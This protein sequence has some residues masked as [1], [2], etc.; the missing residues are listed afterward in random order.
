MNTL[1]A[2][3]PRAGARGHAVVIEDVSADSTMLEGLLRAH[4][5]APSIH[6]RPDVEPALLAG[7][8]PRVIIL[9]ADVKNGFN[10]CLRFRKDPQLR[11]VPLILMTAKASPEVIRKHKLLATRADAYLTKPLTEMAVMDTLAELLPA[12]FGP[13]ARDFEEAIAEIPD[14]TLVSNGTLES[15]VVNYVEEEVRTLKTVVERLMNEKSNLG[16]KVVDLESQMRSQRQILDSG[17][18]RLAPR[19]DAENTDSSQAEP[20]D[21]ED[22]I[23]TTRQEGY[24]AGLQA[25]LETGRQDRRVKGVEQGRREGRAEAQIEFEGQREEL[26][27]NIATL[28]GRIKELETRSK[29]LET[30]AKELAGRE[31]GYRAELDQTTELFERLEGGYKDALAKTEAERSN[32]D[33]S[34]AK[35]EAERD[36]MA[37]RVTALAEMTQ[38]LAERSVQI[39]ALEAEIA[40]LQVRADAFTA[41]GARVAE[42]EKELSDATFE[43]MA[44]RE[45]LADLQPLRKA[46]AA[47]RAEIDRLQARLLRVREA[48]E[49]EEDPS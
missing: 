41:A 3:R 8:Q 7:A 9:S 48:L 29:E 45:T 40:S 43:L 11:H 46:E 39:T 37:E 4:G 13:E 31:S 33:K 28:T 17:L 23:E 6:D 42:L 19:Q 18:E 26:E 49:A 25:G 22:I 20:E 34:L 38:A 1:Q 2:N 15:A 24:D 27:E 47:G 5:Y 14:R 30:R 21:I 10:L 12:D 32:A 35:A 36:E 16:G 44:A